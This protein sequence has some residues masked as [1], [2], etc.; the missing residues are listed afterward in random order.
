MCMCVCL[1]WICAFFLGIL[2]GVTR[3]YKDPLNWIDN[4][5]DLECMTPA[6]NELAIENYK[7]T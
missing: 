4:I 2:S 6:L 1:S 5:R 3:K 7:G